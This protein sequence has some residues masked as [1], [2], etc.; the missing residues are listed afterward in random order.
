ML[1]LLLLVLSAVTLA[2]AEPPFS[3]IGSSINSKEAQEYLSPMLRD[4]MT[5]RYGDTTHFS[6][7]SKGLELAF[8]TNGIVTR[9]WCHAGG[10]GFTQFKGHLPACLT[11]SMTRAD[12]ERLLGVPDRAGGGGHN[13]NFWADYP[14]QKLMVTYASLSV[15]NRAAKI[16]HIAVRQ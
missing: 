9:V 16:S 11:F 10:D 15:T 6:Y 4:R 14:D 7:K 2:A 5:T 1:R 8:G 12:V 13:V 3:L